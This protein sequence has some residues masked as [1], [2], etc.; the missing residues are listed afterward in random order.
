[1]LGPLEASAPDSHPLLRAV[2]W[3]QK[4]S[5]GSLPTK[6]NTISTAPLFH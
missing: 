5:V 6:V 2:R 1:M 3:L 4:E